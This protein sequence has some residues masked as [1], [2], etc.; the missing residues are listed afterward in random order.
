MR[1]DCDCIKEKL[2]DQKT[3]IKELNENIEKT[4]ENL[5]EIKLDITMAALEFGH[6]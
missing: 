6:F 1:K 2:E 5:L 3:D 4:K